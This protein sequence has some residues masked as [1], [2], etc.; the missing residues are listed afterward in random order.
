LS[1]QPTP[2]RPR[3]RSR[4]S[5]TTERASPADRT[6]LAL[7]LVPALVPALALAPV[8]ADMVCNRVETEGPVAKEIRVGTACPVCK[9]QAGTAHRADRVR[10]AWASWAGTAPSVEGPEHSDLPAAAAPAPDL[11]VPAVMLA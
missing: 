7:A 9:A 1:Q 2:C 4:D 5:R 6:A 11:A 10:S 8:P 3:T